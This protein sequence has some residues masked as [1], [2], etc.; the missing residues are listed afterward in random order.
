MVCGSSASAA[1]PIVGD[2]S[3]KDSRG[4]AAVFT[5]P[6]LPEQ[7]RMQTIDT[8]TWRF[9][10]TTPTADRVYLVVDGPLTPSRWIE[11]RPSDATPS[12]WSVDAEIT[13]GQTRVRYFVAEGNAYLNCG[14]VGLYSEPVAGKRLVPTADDLDLVA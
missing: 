3:S 8:Q 9:S 1:C 13:P 5:A 6:P 7:T 10:T 11:M 2:P 14:N 4:H 12:V